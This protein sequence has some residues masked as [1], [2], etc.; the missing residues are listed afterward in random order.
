MSLNRGDADFTVTIENWCDQRN[1]KLPKRVERLENFEL[2]ELGRLRNI[3]V[4]LPSTYNSLNPSKKFPVVYM[5][6]G[7]N[8]LDPNTSAFGREWG[9][10]ETIETMIARKQSEGFINP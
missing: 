4:Y 3:L 1:F 10:D 5:H 9:V 7:Q 8:A 6:D 2:K